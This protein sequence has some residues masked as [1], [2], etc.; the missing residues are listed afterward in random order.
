ML[1]PLMVSDLCP[2]QSSK[3]QKVKKGIIHWKLELPKSD[4]SPC[5]QYS[6][7][8]IARTKMKYEN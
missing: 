6:L 7:G 3:L 8:E 2:I 1:I 5:E 4:V